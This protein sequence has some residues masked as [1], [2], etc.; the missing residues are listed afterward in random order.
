MAITCVGDFLKVVNSLYPDGDSAYF[1]GQENSK[2][3]VN[4]SIF[5]LIDENKSKADSDNFGYRLT[6]NMFIKFKNNFPIYPESQ[7]LQSYSMNELDMLVA[8]QHYGLPTRLIDFTK[9]PL[10]ALYFATEKAKVD[11]TCSVFMVKH[12][13]NSPLMVTTT[14]SFYKS[15]KAEQ[16]QLLDMHNLFERSNFG[17]KEAILN[18][19][20]K[21]SVASF[22][23]D[24][25]YIPTLVNEN[26]SSKQLESLIFT[27]PK[28]AD[29]ALSILQKGIP[30]YVADFSAMKLFG[31][32]NYL[33][34]PL[35]INSRV[36]NQQGLLMFSTKIDEPLFK[37]SDC[38]VI[39]SMTGIESQSEV[40]SLV[41]IDISGEHSASILEELTRYG[42][43][44][45]FIYPE[46]T[47]FTE[48][49]V[50]EMLRKIENK[51]I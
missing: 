13:E 29:N 38:Q 46:I 42:V 28:I 27:D 20:H 49:T 14:N 4:S 11:S 2:F 18:E 12:S 5:R 48:D 35:P 36:R 41:R 21:I 45:S 40:S 7:G 51:K 1:R 19:L 26:F 50:Q 39:K 23:D 32:T 31:N 43:T 10:V 9:N 33:I 16:K 24:Y 30:N 3:D 34:E 17:G 15:V 22:G 37:E 47:S 8:A 44:K 25:E 6:R